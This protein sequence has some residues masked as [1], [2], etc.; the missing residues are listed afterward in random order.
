MFEER[1]ENAGKW[2]EKGLENDPKKGVS[3]TAR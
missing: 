1:W 2:A 3:G